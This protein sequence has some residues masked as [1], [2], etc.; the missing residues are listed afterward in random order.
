MTRVALGSRAQQALPDGDVCADV[1]A[2]ADAVFAVIDEDGNGSITRP[3]LLTHLTKAGYTEAAVNMIF[4]KLDTDKDEQI[5]R[6]EVRRCWDIML[7]RF[8]FDAE[9]PLTPSHR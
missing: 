5:S 9:P 3:E 6:D 8:R 1:E 4:D 2:D 7:A